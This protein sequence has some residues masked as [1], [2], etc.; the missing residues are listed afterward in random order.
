MMLHQILDVDGRAQIYHISDK[1]EFTI[2][3]VVKL[4]S[5]WLTGVISMKQCKHRQFIFPAYLWPMNA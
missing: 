5:I 4:I 1:L 2:W 3:M